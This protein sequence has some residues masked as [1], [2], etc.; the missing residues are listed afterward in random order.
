MV[1]AGAGLSTA[2]GFTYGGERFERYFADFRRRHGF[3]DMYSGGFSPFVDE[4][5]LWAYWS[6][7]IWI[8]RYVDPPRPVYRE[9]AGLL[10][11]REHFVIT[12]NVDSCFAKAGIAHD[13]LFC[14]QGDYGLWQ[15][16]VPCHLA[17]YGNRDAV[18]QMVEAQGYTVA[19]DGELLPP[20]GGVPEHRIP[21]SLVPRCPVCGEPMAMNLRVDGTFVEDEAWHRA[22][23]R[24]RAFLERHEGERVLF[25]ELGVGGNTPGII[26]YPFRRMTKR[27]PL[28]VYACVNRGESMTR[29]AI[30]ERSI[31]VD[32]DAGR[33]IHDLVAMAG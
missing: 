33:V 19:E 24:Y 29:E 3:R 30:E 26:K 32:A 31:L 6:R 2:A 22:A 18:R 13:R 14:P 25:L 12:T 5:E 8:N 20:A 15:C 16:G 4:A 27:N 11:G 9:L 7:F 28:A 10:A 17:T 23:A 1:G 21:E